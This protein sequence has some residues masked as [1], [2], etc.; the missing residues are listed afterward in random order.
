MGRRR[1]V[2]LTPDYTAPERATGESL[3]PRDVE[4]RHAGHTDSGQ[5]SED[6]PLARQPWN[7]RLHGSAEPLFPG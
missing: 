6:T 3:S 7:G 1:T 2:R 5:A 4:G